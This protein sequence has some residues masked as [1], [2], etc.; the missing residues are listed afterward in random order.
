MSISHNV[1][2]GNM[3]PHQE[4]VSLAATV[5]QLGISTSRGVSVFSQNSGYILEVT[6]KCFL[7]NVGILDDVRKCSYL[8]SFTLRAESLILWQPAPSVPTLLPPSLSLS[9]SLSLCIDLFTL[10][11]PHSQ[12]LQPLDSLPFITL[13]TVT[14]TI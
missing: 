9:L 7:L 11:Q 2:Q 6:R 14:E 8:S 4:E 1:A 3:F 5:T 10:F 12:Y 13:R